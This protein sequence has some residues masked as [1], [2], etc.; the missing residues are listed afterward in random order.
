MKALESDVPFAA[1]VVMVQRE[2]AERMVAPVGSKDYGVLT[3][4]VQ[5]YSQ[6]EIVTRVPRSVSSRPLRLT[7]R[8]CGWFPSRRR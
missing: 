5:Y 2:V 6:A 8:W 7:P 4:A 1:L 3:L